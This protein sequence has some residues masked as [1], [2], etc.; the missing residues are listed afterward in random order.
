MVSPIL[1][2]KIVF[3]NLYWLFPK[4]E[5]TVDTDLSCASCRN[6]VPSIPNVTCRP[7]VDFKSLSQDLTYIDPVMSL[8]PR[9][10]RKCGE[11]SHWTILTNCHAPPSSSG[12]G[13]T[14]SQTY[15]EKRRH[16]SNEDETT[17][18]AGDTEVRNAV[19]EAAQQAVLKA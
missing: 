15:T 19:G 7:Q 1:D 12:V 6:G 13:D 8:P 2:Q 14:G 17:G 3:H 9:D 5:I 16:S 11:E 10:C 4:N 18:T